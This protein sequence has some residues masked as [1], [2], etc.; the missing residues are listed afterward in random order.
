LASGPARP[1]SAP[2]SPA[3]TDE[4]VPP[5]IPIPAPNQTRARP[6]AH[7]ARACGLGPA[8]HTASPGLFRGAVQLRRPL[9]PPTLAQSRRRHLRKP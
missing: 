7:A 1:I 5:V 6:R 2:S 3:E 9:S 4:R 8:C